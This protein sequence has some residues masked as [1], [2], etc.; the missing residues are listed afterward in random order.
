MRHPFVSLPF[1]SNGGLRTG[2]GFD[3]DIAAMYSPHVQPPDIL[4]L[5]IV[6]HGTLDLLHVYKGVSEVLVGDHKHQVVHWEIAELDVERPLGIRAELLQLYTFV[7]S[8]QIIDA[9][10]KSVPS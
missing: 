3:S 10:V 6:V 2:T 7:V 1:L 5:E 4:H 8:T 9:N